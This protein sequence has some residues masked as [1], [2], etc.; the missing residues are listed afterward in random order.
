MRLQPLEAFDV[1][2]NGPELINGDQLFRLFCNVAFSGAGD[3]E[4]AAGI[5]DNVFNFGRRQA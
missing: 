2:I 5:L 3:Q 4:G 1:T